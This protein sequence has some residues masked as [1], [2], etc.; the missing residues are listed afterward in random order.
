MRHT[1]HW[2]E[3]TDT[4]EDDIIISVLRIVNEKKFVWLE[5]LIQI[6]GNESKLAII[7]WQPANNR[8]GH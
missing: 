6:L 5:L 4:E 1:K 2:P 7:V 8:T 3:I